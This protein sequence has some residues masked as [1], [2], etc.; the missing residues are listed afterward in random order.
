MTPPRLTSL[1]VLAW[2]VVVTGAIAGGCASTPPPFDESLRARTFDRYWDELDEHY[3]FFGAAGPR[4][5]GVDWNELRD[6]YRPRALAAQ[7]P[8][9]FYHVMVGMLSELDDPH[10]SLERPPAR[11]NE[12]PW[13]SPGL[14]SRAMVDREWYI[15][16]WGDNPPAPPPP[17]LSGRSFVYPRVLRIEGER[18]SITLVDD[19]LVGRAGTPV[20]ID[21]GWPDGAV[22][23]HTLQRPVPLPLPPEI[24]AQIAE[25]LNNPAELRQLAQDTV[26]RLVAARKFGDVG[27]LRVDTFD[28]E[29]AMMSAGD[30]TGILDRAV[31]TVRDCR[32]VIL[33]LRFNPGGEARIMSDFVGRFTDHAMPMGEITLP[34]LWV[35]PVTFEWEIRPREPVCNAR[36]AILTRPLTGS[37]AE[38]AANILR[39]RGDCVIVGSRT[40]GAEAAVETVRGPDGS[41]LNYGRRR[42]VDDHGNGLQFVGVEP[43]VRI[44]MTRELLESMGADAAGRELQRRRFAAALEAL[45]AP[46]LWPRLEAELEEFN[47]GPEP[48]P[49]PVPAPDSP[50]HAGAQPAPATAP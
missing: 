28:P 27:Y 39:Q 47:D 17:E 42:I 33:D 10:V 1:L 25:Q 41:K 16:G 2:T 3:P 23:T 22:T 21:L 38:H 31:D 40:A 7:Y 4:H 18:P 29:D 14:Y 37:S 45:G 9:E 49:E 19:L 20:T 48:E 8:D 50:A 24:A 26:R 36:L 32:A 11:P 30:Y 5:A 13:T 46:D 34:V 15:T 44:D 12:A 43:D 6:R 35:F